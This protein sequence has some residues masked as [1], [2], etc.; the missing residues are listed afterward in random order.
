[1]IPSKNVEV[2]VMVKNN[3]EKN[4]GPQPN[5]MTGHGHGVPLGTSIGV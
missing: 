4:V 1:M 3:L 5:G 2:V